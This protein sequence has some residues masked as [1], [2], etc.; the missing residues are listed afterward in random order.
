MNLKNEIAKWIEH[1]LHVFDLGEKR[2]SQDCV[3]YWLAMQTDEREIILSMSYCKDNKI[4]KCKL[5][6]TTY[7]GTVQYRWHDTQKQL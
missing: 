6:D 5:Q 3:V 7:H 4:M 1:M 2:H